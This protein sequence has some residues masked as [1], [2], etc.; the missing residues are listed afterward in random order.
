MKN[1]KMSNKI[2]REIRL[3]RYF[4]HQNIVRLYEVLDTHADIFVVTEY[5]SGGDLFDIIAQ[6][7]KLSEQDSKNYFRQI[8]AGVDYCHK[9]LV[10]HRD[11]KPENILIDDCGLSNLMR[12]G[13]FL[14][15]SCGSPN[16]AAPE[17]ISGRVYCG[18]EIDTWSCGVILYALLAGYLPFDEEVMAQLFK[19]IREADYVM[20]SSFSAEAKDIVN[21]MLQPD[22]SNRIAFSE[23]RLHPWLRENVPFYIEIFNLNT[24][25]DNQKR[26]NEEAFQRLMQQPNIVL[27][28]LTE[29]KV[30]KAI[31]KR[32]EYSFVI[33]YDLIL[34]DQKRTMISTSN[35]EK[36]NLDSYAFKPI[37]ED[38]NRNISY[39]DNV[40][41]YSDKQIT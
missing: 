21:R 27:H 20:P 7:G 38:L 6:K 28:G 32:K 3:L 2:K 13:K 29:D 22:P 35:N 19:K 10:A 39:I 9:N 18:T 1:S 37:A 17:V 25:M 11:L 8:V 34:D 31:N 26:I 36:K 40:Y 30:R 23:I 5:I 14:K 4:N 33:A 41:N 15:T 24:K 16:Y 12:D